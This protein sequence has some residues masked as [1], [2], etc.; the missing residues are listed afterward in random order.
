MGRRNSCRHCDTAVKAQETCS[1]SARPEFLTPYLK[2][3]GSSANL[4]FTGSELFNII[5]QFHECVFI[6]YGP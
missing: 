4:L 3:W 5:I 1:V 6:S 2:I